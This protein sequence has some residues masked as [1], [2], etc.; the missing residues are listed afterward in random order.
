MNSD[1]PIVSH[2]IV[3]LLTTFLI[4]TNYWRP[5]DADQCPKSYNDHVKCQRRVSLQLLNDEKWLAVSIYKGL[6]C[7]TCTLMKKAS[8]VEEKEPIM[9][10]VEVRN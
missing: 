8:V 5:T 6:W 3:F 1:Y 9:V 4:K 2:K 7:S 10:K